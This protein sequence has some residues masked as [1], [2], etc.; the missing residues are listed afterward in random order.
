MARRYR[1]GA[2]V[3]SRALH[4]ALLGAAQVRWPQRA[5]N[6]APGLSRLLAPRP[7][8]QAHHGPAEPDIGLEEVPRQPPALGVHYTDT[9]LR[10]RIATLRGLQIPGRRGV[11]VRDPGE[12]KLANPP[13]Q[14]LGIHVAAL[15]LRRQRARCVLILPIHVGQKTFVRFASRIRCK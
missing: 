8:R 12:T 1:L 11:L 5:A 4:Q 14:E 3:L 10:C 7:G 2:R 6:G 9:E 15:R 13:H